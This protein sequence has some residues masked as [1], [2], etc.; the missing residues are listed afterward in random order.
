MLHVVCGEEACEALRKAALVL[1]ALEF[2][3]HDALHKAH[4]LRL[5]TGLAEL[6]ELAPVCPAPKTAAQPDAAHL[7][8]QIRRTH[9]DS[10]DDSLSDE[11]QP[12]SRELA[13]WQQALHEGQA[14]SVA[15]EG[16]DRRPAACPTPDSQG[17]L[18]QCIVFDDLHQRGCATRQRN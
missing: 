5:G 3:W 7:A 16:G 9:R 17:H 10:D 6:Y 13:P 2:A 11:W 18:A 1:A 8:A 14:L 15:E 4:A 12:L